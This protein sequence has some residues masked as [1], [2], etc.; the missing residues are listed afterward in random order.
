M[1][2]A[3]HAELAEE[4]GVTHT[5]P[6][7]VQFVY[8]PLGGA[9]QEPPYDDLDPGVRETVRWLYDNEFNPTDS[10]DGV[11]KP[12]GGNWCNRPEPHVYMVVNQPDLLEAEVERLWTLL[13][14][15]KVRLFAGPMTPEAA[16]ELGVKWE[17]VPE[18]VV[19]GSL[20]GS[21]APGG[22]ALIMLVGLN[23]VIMGLRDGA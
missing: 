16:E 14:G 17:G 23:D 2:D 10:G 19:A 13:Q 21:Y 20:E 4:M 15:R 7:S 3:L 5:G 1:S 22:P 12:T 18:G 8:A 9:R 6:A 11:S